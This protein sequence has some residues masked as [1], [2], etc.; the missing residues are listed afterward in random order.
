MKSKTVQNTVGEAPLSPRKQFSEAVAKEIK[1]IEARAPY[2]DEQ[3]ADWHE[4]DLS[5]LAL[6][7]DASVGLDHSSAKGSI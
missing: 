5:V 1:I 3:N 4:M 2:A 7:L 6:R